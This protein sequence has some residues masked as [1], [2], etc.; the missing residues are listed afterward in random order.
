MIVDP[1]QAEAI[2]AEGLADI[3]AI[4]RA[5]LDDRRWVWHAA[6]RLDALEEI[7]YPPQY[8][9]AGAPRWRGTA[10]P[11]PDEAVSLA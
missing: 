9:R 2:I 6:E 10:L 4:G 3:V 5:F 7:Q 8:E 11:R 1:H